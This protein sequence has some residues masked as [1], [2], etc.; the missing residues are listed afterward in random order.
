[1]IGASIHQRTL[2]IMAAPNQLSINAVNARI[3]LAQARADRIAADFRIAAALRPT[4]EAE[5]LVA[6]DLTRNMRGRIDTVVAA[7]P[8]LALFLTNVFTEFRTG[9]DNLLVYLENV[10]NDMHEANGNRAAGA[11]AAPLIMA[12]PVP[13]APAP[14]VPVV[15]APAPVVPVVPAQPEDQDP[16]D[17]LAALIHAPAGDEPP[18][19]DDAPGALLD[20]PAGDEPP[21]LDDAPGALLDEPADDEPILVIVVEADALPARRAAESDNID[22]RPAQRRR[23]EDNDA[24]CGGPGR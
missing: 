1:V 4:T 20:A 24:G 11:P 6:R 15:P 9:L 21:A 14:V 2:L 10:I 16:L 5:L 23:I 8:L 19:L 13:P 17:R 18:A 12:A 3:A 7:N 22:V